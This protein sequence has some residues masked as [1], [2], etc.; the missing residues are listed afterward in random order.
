[1]IANLRLLQLLQSN[2]CNRAQTFF[3]Y[4]KQQHSWIQSS[5]IN[6]TYIYI[7]KLFREFQFRYNTVY[8]YLNYA[9]VCSWLYVTILK[10]PP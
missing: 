2:L 9:D 10:G 4:N 3:K 8:T 1:M 6:Y 5:R 7:R